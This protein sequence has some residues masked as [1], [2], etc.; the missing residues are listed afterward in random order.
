MRTA[1]Y[2]LLLHKLGRNLSSISSEHRLAESSRHRL[3]SRN[4]TPAPQSHVCPHQHRPPL[5]TPLQCTHLCSSGR[6]RSRIAPRIALSQCPRRSS[7]NALRCRPCICARW[8]R[9]LRRWRGG[10]S[11]GP[12]G[13]V[14]GVFG[15]LAAEVAHRC[16]RLDWRLGREK[17]CGTGA[18]NRVQ[19]ECGG[20][21]RGP[22][23]GGEVAVRAVSREERCQGPGPW[24]RQVKS[25]K[26][27]SWEKHCNRDLCC[28]VEVIHGRKHPFSETVV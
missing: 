26:V 4:V 12:A 25:D 7:N 18:A 6:R 19:T 10:R 17:E 14:E 8:D 22:S 5:P 11:Q 16:R 21:P 28:T 24:M 20:Q 15:L 13:A 3:I 9:G 23:G 27:L 2:L 1:R